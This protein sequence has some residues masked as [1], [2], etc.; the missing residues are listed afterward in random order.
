MAFLAGCAAGASLVGVVLLL[1]GGLLSPIP[2]GWRLSQLWW[3][4]L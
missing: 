2:A 4:P 3:G 1:A